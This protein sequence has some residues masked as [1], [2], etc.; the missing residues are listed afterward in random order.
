MSQHFLRI[1]GLPERCILQKRLTKAFFEKHFTLT[2]AEKKLLN[3]GIE[4]MD[5][6]ASIKAA[7]IPA[8]L[9][10]THSYEEVQVF[11]VQLRASTASGRVEKAGT[12]VAELLQKYLPYHL[13]LFVYDAENYLVNVCTK[14][15]NQNDGSKRT[16]EANITSPVLSLLYADAPTKTFHEALHFA[17]LD[18]SDLRTLYASYMQAVV[19]CRAAAITGSF[20]KRP[21][22]RSEQDLVTLQRIDALEAEIRALQAKVKK[23]QALREQVALNMDIQQSREEVE[24]LRKN[25]ERE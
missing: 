11:A 24:M 10:E 5:W 22:V 7:H 23:G 17:Q 16:L 18:K 8:Y 14:R 12:K 21:H 20:N 3:E 2:A 6:L 25:L 13:L 15:I 4:H 1:L 9:T 19:Q